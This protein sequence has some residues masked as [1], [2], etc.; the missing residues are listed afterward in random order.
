MSPH[1]HLPDIGNLR[2][3]ASP[4]RVAIPGVGFSTQ[5]GHPLTLR[6]PADVDRVTALDRQSSTLS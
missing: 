4:P 5:T 1:V 2:M 3:S 6:K